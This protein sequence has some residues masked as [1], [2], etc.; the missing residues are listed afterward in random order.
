MCRQAL[1]EQEIRF[2]RPMR[3]ILAGMEGKVHVIESAQSL[4][5]FAFTGQGLRS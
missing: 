1:L 3:L 5:P 4:L 2:Q